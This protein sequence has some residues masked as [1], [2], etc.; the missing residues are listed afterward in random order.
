MV[1]SLTGEIWV[2]NSGANQILRYPEFQTL[3]INGPTPTAT[4]LAFGPLTIALD[5]TD[6]IV[7]L[8]AANRMTFYYASLAYR[9]SANYNQVPL[10]PGMLADLY[11]GL[12]DHSSG[13]AFT[14]IADAATNAYPWP[15][16]LSDAIKQVNGT[17]GPHLQGGQRYHLFPG[18]CQHTIF[19]ASGFC[20]LAS[21]HRVRFSQREPSR[22]GRRLPAFIRLVRMASARYPQETTT[23][24][25]P[26]TRH[27]RFHEAKSFPST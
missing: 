22:C 23:A 17:P 6:N 25:Q 18:A 15:T 7:T 10:A 13:S 24:S 26:M 4:L 8:D 16:T 27:M 3:Q 2:A 20:C 12:V 21:I 14:G 5:A 9:H 11:L 19:R 1:S